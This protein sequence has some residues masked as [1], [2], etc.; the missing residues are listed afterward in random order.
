M[1]AKEMQAKIEEQGRTIEAMTTLHQA[2]QEAI[3]ASEDRLTLLQQAVDRLMQAAEFVGALQIKVTELGDHQ[4]GMNDTLHRVY[5]LVEGASSG[6]DEGEETDEQRA[7]RIGLVGRVGHLE[8]LVAGR[9]RSAP[10]KRNMTDDDARRVLTGD[11]K[12]LGHKEAGEVV[13]LTYAQ[14]YSCRLE[15][16]F[17]HV[18]KELREAGWKNHW[19]KK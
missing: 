7:A 2:F 13:G 9:N 8:T 3:A 14:V 11:A 17:K 6:V 1:N 10:V 18:H 5:C 19:A 12:D 15:Y 4:D 16:T